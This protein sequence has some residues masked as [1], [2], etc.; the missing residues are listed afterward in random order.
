MVHHTNPYISAFLI[1]WQIKVFIV[2]ATITVP[3]L[4]R[5]ASATV[6]MDVIR[7]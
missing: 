5:R 3:A 1:F 4:P 2:Y 7:T 6:L